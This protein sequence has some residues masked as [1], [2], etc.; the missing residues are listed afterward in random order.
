MKVRE[1]IEILEDQDPNAEVVTISQPSWPFEYEVA[2]VTVRQEVRR[3]EREENG[4]EDDD[5]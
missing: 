4:E 1:L 2:G 5:V 3:A